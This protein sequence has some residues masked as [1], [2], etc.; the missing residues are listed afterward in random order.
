[1]GSHDVQQICLNGHQ[2]TDSFYHSPE[3]RRKF[4]STCGAETIHK[5][6]KCN[7]EIKGDY[8]VEGVVVLGGSTSVPTHCENCGNTFPWTSNSNNK[9]S[10]TLTQNEECSLK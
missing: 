1:M 4:C 10:E 3:F 6:P 9:S 7:A 2:I 8:H 5:C